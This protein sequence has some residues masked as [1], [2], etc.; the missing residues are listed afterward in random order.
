MKL[1]TLIIAAALAAGAEIPAERVYVNGTVVTLDARASTAEA[2]AVSRGEI[3]AV[4]S[5]REIERRIGPAT[6]VVD[7]QGKTLLP[8]LYSAHDHFPGSGVTAL[9]QVDLNS[10]PIGAMESIE[11]VVAALKRK[12]EVR[13]RASGWWGAATTIRCCARN[14]IRTA[15]TS[16]ASPRATPW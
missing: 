9:F 11:D 12:A 4:G 1:I 15:T 3:V 14:A 8:G 2:V 13:R 16:T 7:L 6:M 5:R 10:P